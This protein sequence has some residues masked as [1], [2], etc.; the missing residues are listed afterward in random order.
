MLDSSSS[1]SAN[2]PRS[3]DSPARRCTQISSNGEILRTRLWTTSGDRTRPAALD[4][5]VARLKVDP[6]IRGYSLRH[7][8]ED[9]TPEVRYAEVAQW[10]QLTP[11]VEVQRNLRL[12][13]QQVK[14]DA[15][16]TAPKA[17]IDAQ[18]SRATSRIISTWDETA[19]PRTGPR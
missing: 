7:F 12:L 3:K 9:Q 18:I 15:E 6:I 14:A 11:L 1:P 5:L 2:P 13:R 10:L 8:V 17:L 16:D 4:E 19:G